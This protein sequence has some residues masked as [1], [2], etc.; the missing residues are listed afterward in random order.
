MEQLARVVYDAGGLIE[1]L[2][3]KCEGGH[4]VMPSPYLF[5]GT[6]HPSLVVVDQRFSLWLEHCEAPED[7]EQVLVK[8]EDY[9]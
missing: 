5:G 6:S 9:W 3:L 7:M 2:P 1:V 4:L 8:D